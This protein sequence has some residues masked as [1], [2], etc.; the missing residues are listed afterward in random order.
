MYPHCGTRVLNVWKRFTLIITAFRFSKKKKRTT[1]LL[2][3]RSM[4]RARPF[5]ISRFE[6]QVTDLRLVRTVVESISVLSHGFNHRIY[7]M[8]APLLSNK[9]KFNSSLVR[10]NLSR[11]LIFWRSCHTYILLSILSAILPH[12]FSRLLTF[13]AISGQRRLYRI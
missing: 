3:I 1:R 8:L 6:Q 5:A 10:G 2:L 11:R 9:G 12:Y 13:N 4:S 7:S